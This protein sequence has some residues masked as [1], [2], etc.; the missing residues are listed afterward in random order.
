VHPLTCIE[1]AGGA[2]VNVGQPVSPLVSRGRWSRWW[3]RCC[4]CLWVNSCIKL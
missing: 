1:P 3:S 4:T 2:S